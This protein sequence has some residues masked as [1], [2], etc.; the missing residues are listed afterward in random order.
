VPDNLA[1]HSQETV[2]TPYGPVRV[3][4]HL[5]DE[6]LLEVINATIHAFI[7]LSLEQTAGGYQSLLAVY[8]IHTHW[9]SRYYLLLIEPFRRW[10]I[11]PA[12]IRTIQRRWVEVYGS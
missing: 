11:Y 8:A 2:G 5:R 1:A 4:Y 6:V 10:I 9:W 3:I 12:L 7:S